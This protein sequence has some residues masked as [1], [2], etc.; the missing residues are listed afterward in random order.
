ME[1][2]AGVRER[3]HAMAR[4]GIGATEAKSGYGLEP[5]SEARMLQA[6]ARAA[7]DS[8]ITVRRTFLGGHAIPPDDAAWPERLVREVI[9]DFARRYPDAAVDAFCEKNAFGV[10][11]CSSQ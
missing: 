8:P 3:L 7:S 6:I 4:L 9:P 1:L 2:A 10:P 11:R 5:A